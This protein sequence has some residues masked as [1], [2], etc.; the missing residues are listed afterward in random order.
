MTWI[1]YQHWFPI[2]AGC[3]QN[4]RAGD[5]GVPNDWWDITQY[6]FICRILSENHIAVKIK[7][8]SSD[9]YWVVYEILS[10]AI[11]EFDVSKAAI[12]MATMC[13]FRSYSDALETSLQYP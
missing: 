1:H 2:D 10:N 7:R 3:G 6:Q 12:N 8:L 5:I 13:I 4:L 9:S 11:K